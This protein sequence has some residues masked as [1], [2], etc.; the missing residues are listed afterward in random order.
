MNGLEVEVGNET[1]PVASLKVQTVVFDFVCFTKCY[2]VCERPSNT[3]LA[4]TNIFLQLHTVYLFFYCTFFLSVFYLLVVGE[5][6]L[7]QQH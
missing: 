1:A 2:F 4:A 7:N 6:G 5:G 3:R